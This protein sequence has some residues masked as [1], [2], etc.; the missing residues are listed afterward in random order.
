M[1]KR[2]E[3]AAACPKLAES[4]RL[5]PTVGALA[6]LAECEEHEH[7]LVS[8]Y[9]RWHQALNLAHAMGD[10]RAADVEHELARLEAVVPK[11]RVLAGGPLPPDALLRVDDVDLGA[12]SLGV[13]L[14]VE[15][16]RHTLQASAQHKVTWST[17][18]ETAAD[19]AT[20]S[21]TIPVLEDAPTV[22]LAPAPM[23]PART[24]SSSW[25]TVG[26]VAAGAGVATIAVGSA[27]GVVAMRQRDE[28][29]CPGNLCPDD[30]DADTLRRAKATANWSTALFVTGGVLLAGG[31]SLWWIE[32]DHSRAGVR[33]VLTPTGVAGAF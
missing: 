25:A 7:R 31:A 29:G 21:V 6:K 13:P 2:G 5:E 27:L 23:P 11:V 1:M 15:P 14:A 17:T 8:A 16:G 19:G 20:T 32:R 28:A 30:A 10:A 24:G 18:I 22:S 3:Y 12:A 26:L 33:A 9:G 4:A